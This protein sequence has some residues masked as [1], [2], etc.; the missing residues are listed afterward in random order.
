MTSN[1]QGT[2]ARDHPPLPGRGLNA[3]EPMPPAPAAAPA[4]TPTARDGSRGT[5]ESANGAAHPVAPFAVSPA[6][7]S[8]PF[9]GAEGGPA[10][11][12]ARAPAA[13][14]TRG[15]RGHQDAARG[16]AVPRA[17]RTSPPASEGNAGGARGGVPGATGVGAGHSPAQGPAGNGRSSEA[18]PAGVAPEAAGR[19][20]PAAAA[21]GPEPKSGQAGRDAWRKALSEQAA[22][23]R[24]ARG[25]W[26]PRGTAGV[27]RP[28]M[29]RRRAE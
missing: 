14:R 19:L 27:P 25:R 16:K 29:M 21:S 1:P 12:P 24:R 5:P 3:A 2:T 17:A 13:A 22:E 10:D 9:P 20:R 7:G 11:P 26:T 6:Q 4:A 23:K 8:S 15:G 28:G 18:F